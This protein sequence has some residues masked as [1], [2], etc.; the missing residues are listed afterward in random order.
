MSLRIG[1]NVSAIAARRNLGIA[2]RETEHA[3]KS[4]A[5]GKRIVNSGDDAAGFAIGETLRGQ[6]S[7]LKQSKFNA[8]SAISFIQVAEGSL[9]EQNNIII[10]LR[11]LGV[12]AASDTLDDRERGFLQ[13]EF[14]QLVSEFDRIAKSTRYGSN[15]L[16]TGNAKEYEFQLGANPDPENVVK[17]KLDVDT[18]AAEFDLESLTVEEK[19]DARDALSVLDEAV[20]RIADVRSNFGAIQSR[21]MTARDNLDVQ[22]ENI[23]AAKSQILDA[24]VAE[25]TA[26]LAKGRVQTEFASAVLAQANS[27]PM[28]VMQLIG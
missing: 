13:Q 7:G 18:T 16:L 1:S 17:Y 28:A 21:L 15:T 26:K 9:N 22:V 24:D 4:L 11:E 8:E 12:Q 27:S 20:Y 14:T 10:R 2:Q 3:L 23:S 6:L 19:D 25:A 5:S